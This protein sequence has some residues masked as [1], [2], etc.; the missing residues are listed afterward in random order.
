MITNI[1]ELRE[2]PIGQ[3]VR[4]KIGECIYIILPTY[5]EEDRYNNGLLFTVLGMSE[6]YKY[7]VA[8]IVYG[9][10]VSSGGWP[11]FRDRDY[12]SL[13]R[14]INFLY[15]C[16][17]VKECCKSTYEDAISRPAQEFIKIIEHTFNASS[18]P[19]VVAPQQKEP[20][21]GDV[22]SKEIVDKWLFAPY[23]PI[24]KEEM[25][26]SWSENWKSVSPYFT[27]S[28]VGKV[29]GVSILRFV[30]SIIGVEIQYSSTSTNILDGMSF[31]ELAYS[32]GWR[33]KSEA[34]QQVINTSNHITTNTNNGNIIIVSRITPT[35][36]TGQR[37][38]GVRV[39]GRRRSSTAGIG[40]L[41][42][43][44]ATGFPT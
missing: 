9:Y 41:S 32:M 2:T 31:M 43:K 7:Q 11:S 19:T 1:K 40:H 21:I 13:V 35:I 6:E 33:P 38:T 5:C 30:E 12:V 4:F 34:K 18:I 42:N 22:F 27:V 17:E 16:V 28:S 39:S 8:S 26:R 24:Y 20:K 36:T 14:L 44:A 3:G 23:K 29:G 37:P 15:K 25:W 10:T